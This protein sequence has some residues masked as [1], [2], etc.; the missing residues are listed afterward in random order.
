MKKN[1]LTKLVSA[2]FV[3]ALLAPSALAASSW[4]ASSS[5]VNIGANLPSDFEPSG[6][7]Y[8]DET[9]WLYVVSD[10]GVVARMTTSGTNI[11]TW[12]VGDDLEGVTKAGSYLYLAEEK[13]NAM[14][15]FN[16]STGT[17]TGR[18][19]SFSSW[20]PGDGTND[21]MEGLTYG[22]GYFYTSDSAGKVYVFS[23]DLNGSS[24]SLVNSFNPTS[25][26]SISDLSYNSSTETLYVMYRGSKIAE[27][28]NGSVTEY[29]LPANSSGSEALAFEVNCSSG[30]ANVYVGNDPAATHEVWK[31]SGYPMTCASAPSPEPEP[32]PEPTPDPVE[33]PEYLQIEIS[34]DRVDNDGDG[35]VDEYN[36]VF[37]NGVHPTYGDFDLNSPSDFQ[38]A[39]LSYAGL[40]DGKVVVTFADNS[41]YLYR[42]FEIR[43]PKKTLLSTNGTGLFY[44]QNP[45]NRKVVQ[46]NIFTGEKL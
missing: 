40:R 8:S 28:K 31:Y 18:S 29:S 10:E 32:S 6:A 35:V 23:V 39:V 44:A 21:A 11:T 3:L 14:Y 4:P 46:L 19:W 12:N 26:S 38:V 36:T 22:N 13:Q 25:S 27:W 17:L 2:L 16:A 9:G 24:V 34:G 5:G 30:S 33:E 45:K 41:V 7:Y 42:V 20:M 43:T 37:E 15:E 1:L